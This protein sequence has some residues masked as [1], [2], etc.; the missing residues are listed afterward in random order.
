M[1]KKITSPLPEVT[2]RTSQESWIDL[3][4]LAQVEVTSEDG[5]HPIESALVPGAGPGWRAAQ[6]GQQTIRIRLDE[7]QRLRRILLVFEERERART[8]EFVLRW[9]ADGGRTY[10]EIVRQQYNFSPPGT[11]REV[12]NYIA[13]LEGVTVVEL[14]VV[15]DVGGGDSCASLTMLRLG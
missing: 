7:P 10:R 1:R 8:Q 15:P 12:E 11:P 3:E 14:T 13:E 9:S 5:A 6:P 2:P 4:R